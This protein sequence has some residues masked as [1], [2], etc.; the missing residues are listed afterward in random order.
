MKIYQRLLADFNELYLG[1][2][3]IGIIASSCI[4][5]VA[6]MLILMNG[7]TFINMFELFLV[8]SVCMGFNA[9]VLAQMSHKFVFNSL[10]I[11]IFT[12]LFFIVINI[13]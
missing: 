1:Y 11:S 8:V 2:A 3:S 13:I 4:G 5:S 7:H 12:S 10:I 9:T 6:A